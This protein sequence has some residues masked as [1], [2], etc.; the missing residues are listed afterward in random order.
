MYP[1]QLKFFLRVAAC[2]IASATHA[3]ATDSEHHARYTLHALSPSSDQVDL[4]SAIIETRFPKQVHTVSDSIDYILHRS[5]YRHLATK[6]I[7]HSLHLPLPSSHRKI[8]PTDIRSALQ[9]IVGSSWRLKEDRR[10]RVIWFQL[11]GAPPDFTLE[12]PGNA[13]SSGS[14]NQL[15]PQNETHISYD[16]PSDSAT[17]FIQQAWTLDTSGSLRENLHRWASSVNWSL[18]W[19]SQ[20]DYQIQH[21]TSFHGTLSDA[22][23]QVL[24]HYR[25]APIPLKAT[26]YGGNKVLRVEPRSQTGR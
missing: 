21:S 9:T 10:R 1:I 2:L 23:N 25:S 4:L 22:V 13:I 7:E 16:Q 3:A 20:H 12:Q 24:E 19:G 26:F 11:A 8:G 17:I 18:A 14:A 5:G 6:D 15:T